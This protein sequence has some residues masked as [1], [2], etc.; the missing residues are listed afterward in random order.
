VDSGYAIINWWHTADI[1]PPLVTLGSSPI[2]NTAYIPGLSMNRQ[3]QL[4]S[5]QVI[6][7]VYGRHPQLTV[8]VGFAD[9]HIARTKA[10]NLFVKN[11][12]DDNYENRSPLW[13]PDS[14]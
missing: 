1:L 13:V 12:G 2:E 14:K 6:D 11:I 3:R 10:E 5:E 9:G 8:N 7:A 4:L